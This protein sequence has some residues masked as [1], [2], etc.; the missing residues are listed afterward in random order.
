[1]TFIEELKS[2]FDT[3]DKKY[4]RSYSFKEQTL[5]HKQDNEYKYYVTTVLEKVGGPYRFDYYAFNV[6]KCPPRN[7]NLLICY[8]CTMEP[9]WIPLGKDSKNNEIFS[10]NEDVY[11]PKYMRRK[12]TIDRVF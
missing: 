4:F 6:G 10:E 3:D 1:M 8:I 2:L 12:T 11:N 7:D 9:V 5:V